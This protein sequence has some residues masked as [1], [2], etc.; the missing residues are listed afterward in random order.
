MERA[1]VESRLAPGETC[2]GIGDLVVVPAKARTESVE[3]KSKIVANSVSI[4]ELTA[5]QVDA[6]VAS[7]L[8]RGNACQ[9]LLIPS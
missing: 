7:H 8:A 4:A 6:A 9:H 1:L 2:L 3:S 5:G